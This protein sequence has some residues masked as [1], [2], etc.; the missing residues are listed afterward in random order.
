MLAFL[1]V[2]LG[3]GRL[4]VSVGRHRRILLSQD[5]GDVTC[6]FAFPWS[7]SKVLG[8][9]LI[10]LE[11]GNSAEQPAWDLE[12]V[13]GK[14][15]IALDP[16]PLALSTGPGQGLQRRVASGVASPS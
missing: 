7:E 11:E 16:G 1:V 9:V 12:E 5:I 15:N 10:S 4:V 13:L 3:R 8:L 2:R 14:L 6:F